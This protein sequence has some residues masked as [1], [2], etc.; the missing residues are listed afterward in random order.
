[1]HTD[2]TNTETIQQT[3]KLNNLQNLKILSNQKIHTRYC[4][5]SHYMKL[6]KGRVSTDLRQ[7]FFSERIINIL[8]SAGT[9][10]C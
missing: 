3:I 5:D 8:E 6:K 7:H 4:R 9:I 2:G 1:M 10:Y